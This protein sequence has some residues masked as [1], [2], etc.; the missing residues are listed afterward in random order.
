MVRNLSISCF[1]TLMT[2]DVNTIEA[3]AQFLH[4]H[5]VIKGVLINF[6][7]VQKISNLGWRSTSRKLGICDTIAQ[8]FL[9]KF[10]CA[11]NTA[12]E[13]GHALDPFS[14]P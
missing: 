1:I 7:R 14:S 11:F 4:Q 10:F 9:Y 2:A 3:F 6:V 5:L 13:E 12:A 8:L